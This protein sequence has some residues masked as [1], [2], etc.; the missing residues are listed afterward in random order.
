MLDG[1][2]ARMS[3]P[4]MEEGGSKERLEVE[5]NKI[6]GRLEAMMMW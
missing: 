6:L 4:G 3:V 1:G 2:E 5:E